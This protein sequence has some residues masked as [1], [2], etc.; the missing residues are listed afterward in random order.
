MLVD[1]PM[2]KAIIAFSGFGVS[3]MDSMM[4]RI[5]LKVLLAMSEAATD[6]LPRVFILP[7]GFGRHEWQKPTTISRGQT[8]SKRARSEMY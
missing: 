2:D 6:Q 7:L 8:S 1:L 3:F 4:A 5:G